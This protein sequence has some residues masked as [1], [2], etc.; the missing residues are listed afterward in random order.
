MEIWCESEAD[1]DGTFPLTQQCR[2]K[3][4]EEQQCYTCESQNSWVQK[5]DC[6]HDVLCDVKTLDD[7]HHVSDADRATYITSGKS[8]VPEGT[9]IQASCTDAEQVYHTYTCTQVEGTTE[10]I[11][12]PE[13]ADVACKGGDD[14]LFCDVTVMDPAY[15]SS[16]SCDGVM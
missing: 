8:T 13:S 12:V 3:I 5:D 11:W 1:E 2:V 16:G 6:P 7:D 9:Q 10:G 15:Q 14:A 4:N